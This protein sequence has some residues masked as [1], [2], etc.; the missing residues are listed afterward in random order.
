MKIFIGADHQGAI[1]VDDIIN[2]LKEQ[3]HEV[4]KT[5][6]TNSD[7]DDYPDFAYDV[8]KN[9]ISNNALGILICGSGIGISIAANKVKGIRCARVFNTEDAY[10][11][12]N[13][14]GCNVIAFSASLNI[15]SIKEILDTFINTP[16]PY[17]E[18]HLRR[19]D[20]VNRIEENNYEL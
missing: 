19:I 5:K 11:C 10:T 6:L 1:L 15:E 4:Y 14:N 20:K 13:H 3:N 9:V 16:Y 17:E 12:K 2:Y 7:M 8:C 18:R